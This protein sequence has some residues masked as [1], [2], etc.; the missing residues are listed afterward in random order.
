MQG[1]RGTGNQFLTDARKSGG[2]GRLYT[3]L[4]PHCSTFFII[5]LSFQARFVDF[6]SK[7]SLRP[8]YFCIPHAIP[9]SSHV[10]WHIS[11]YLNILQWMHASLLPPIPAKWAPVA[12]QATAPSPASAR[13]TS[14]WAPRLKAHPRAPRPT[15]V[16]ESRACSLIHITFCVIRVCSVSW[17]RGLTNLEARGFK[18]GLCRE[19]H[20]LCS[21]SLNGACSSIHSHL[22][23]CHPTHNR[24]RYLH[25]LQREAGGPATPEPISEWP[26]TWDHCVCW[27]DC[28]HY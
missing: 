7:R 19:P 6:S 18:G 13:M 10:C 25:C 23:S 21:L 28:P 24:C 27:L 26:T 5:W 1:F 17:G 14:T 16:R 2:Q 22:H 12:T 3:H 15:T 20:R 9:P 8:E 11:A 4:Y